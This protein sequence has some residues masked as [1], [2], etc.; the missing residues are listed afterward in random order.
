MAGRQ[1]EVQEA[2]RWLVPNPNLPEGRPADVAK[3]FWEFTC[4][5]LK[6]TGDGG[7][8]KLAIRRL[9]EAKDAAVRQAITD[10]G[11]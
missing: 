7:Q 5:L 8:L 2:L 4:D 1:P 10:G 6:L 3:L 11:S 9:T